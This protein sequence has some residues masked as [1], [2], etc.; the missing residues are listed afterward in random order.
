MAGQFYLHQVYHN[1]PY[2]CEALEAKLCGSDSRASEGGNNSKLAPFFRFVKQGCFTVG[3]GV[4]KYPLKGIDNHNM[5]WYIYTS[6]QTEAKKK[7]GNKMEIT[8]RNYGEYAS[9]NYGSHTQEVTI[10][11]LRLWFSYDTVIAFN[12]GDGLKVCKN[13]WGSTTGKHLN[14][15]NPDKSR[16]LPGDEFDKQIA[17][18]LKKHK[19]II[20]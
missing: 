2:W 15:I 17:K 20:N 14:W 7:G 9:G 5:V 1:S 6:S 8:K 13:A 16:R 18:V 19:L 10:G 3:G 12:N 4:L 11:D